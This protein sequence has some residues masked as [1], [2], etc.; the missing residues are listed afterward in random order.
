MMNMMLADFGLLVAAAAFNPAAGD[1]GGKLASQCVHSMRS[2]AADAVG[3]DLRRA[4]VMTW[5]MGATARHDRGNE[6]FLARFQTLG[7]DYPKYYP[8]T[9]TPPPVA[10]C[11]AAYPVAFKS[12]DVTLPANTGERNAMCFVIGSLYFGLAKGHADATGDKDPLAR[13]ERVMNHFMT[14]TLRDMDAAGDS[15]ANAKMAA[16]LSQRLEQALDLGNP[17]IISEACFNAIT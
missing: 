13:A 4:S 7:R 14:A 16:I 9:P 10:D 17:Q 8:E 6:T 12:G 3:D 2:D 5:F 1:S 11:Q 15:N